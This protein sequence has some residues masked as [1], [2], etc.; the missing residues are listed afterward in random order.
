M[1]VS[2][3][4]RPVNAPRPGAREPLGLRVTAE[5]KA[6]LAEQAARNGRSLSQ[7]AELRLVQ[8]FRD[9]RVLVAIARL[10]KRLP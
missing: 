5:T 7:E 4:G 6:A 3:V 9:D 10:G 2:R 1:G 8:S